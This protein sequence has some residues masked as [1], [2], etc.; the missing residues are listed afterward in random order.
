MIA[1]E[2]ALRAM[3]GI[4]SGLGFAN[5]NI[6]GFA[7]ILFIIEGVRILGP[8]RPRNISAFSITSSKDLRSVF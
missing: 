7:R 5:A 1:S 6:I 2:A 3:P 8:D 4:T